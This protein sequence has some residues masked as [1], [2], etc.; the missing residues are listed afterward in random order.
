MKDIFR[1]SGLFDITEFVRATHAEMSAILSCAGNGVSPVGKVLYCT[2]F[3][4][5]NCAKHIV[6]SG[7]IEVLFIE[8]YPKSFS[9]ELHRDAI[10]VSGDSVRGKVVFKHFI[11]VAA[12]RYLDLFSMKLGRGKNIKRKNT[13]GIVTPFIRKNADVRVQVPINRYLGSEDFIV[14]ELVSSDWMERNY[15]TQEP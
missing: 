8:P 11:G 2:T 4:C 12:S 5:H 13:D 9:E 10:S 3:P 15:L 7:I 14:G 6:D 1:E